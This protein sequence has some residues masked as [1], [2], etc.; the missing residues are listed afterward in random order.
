MSTRTKAAVSDEIAR[1][2]TLIEDLEKRLR[3]L[4][5]SVKTE[6]SGA[7]SDINDFVSEALAGIMARVR[8]SAGEI[9]DRVA[10]KAMKAGSSA[11]R[12]VGEEID[13]YPLTAL[14][15]AAGIGFLLGSSR[16]S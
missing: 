11:Y 3:R 6:A 14:A 12:K 2:E 7:S 9:T 10:D 13:A 16:R 5:D 1:I 4:N 15:I 8:E